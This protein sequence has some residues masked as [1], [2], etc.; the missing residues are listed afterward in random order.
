MRGAQVSQPTN[1]TKRSKTKTPNWSLP[2]SPPFSPAVA[3]LFFGLVL[4][5][6]TH[7]LFPSRGSPAGLPLLCFSS[8]GFFPSRSY[9]RF[10][11]P[12]GNR[13]ETFGHLFFFSQQQT[14][15]RFVLHKKVFVFSFS[16]HK[17]IDDT[18]TFHLLLLFFEEASERARHAAEM[19]AGKGLQRSERRLLNK[20]FLVSFFLF[21][22]K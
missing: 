18:K 4:S 5:C 19:A 16:F 3:I 12:K 20:G 7:A 11:L 21:S 8:L 9:L 2:G 17:A 6:L 15:S 14:L 13:N 22:L 10:S 1:Q